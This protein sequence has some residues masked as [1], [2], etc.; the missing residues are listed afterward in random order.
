MSHDHSGYLTDEETVDHIYSL[1]KSGDVAS[2]TSYFL[3]LGDDKE[4]LKRW[5][6]VQ[7]DIYNVKKDPYASE[8]IGH[9]AVKFALS[10]DYKQS[11][12]IL[13]HNISSFHMQAWDENVDPLVIPGIIEVAAKQVE[14]REQ[15][16]EKPTLAW[17]YWD[18]GMT[19]LVGSQFDEAIEQFGKSVTLAESIGE[20]NNA[21]WSKLFIGK[22]IVKSDPTRRH[23]GQQI[24]ADAGNFIETGGEDWEKEELVNILATVGL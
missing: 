13:L 15:I 8:L 23:E 7:C 17:A 2:A 19:L 1:V 11:A 6:G 20:T 4:V 22:T 9:E 21:A 3:G 10:K 24:M 5:V 14:L 18:Y 16:G 12:A